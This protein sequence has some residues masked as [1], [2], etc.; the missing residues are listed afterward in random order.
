MR[1]RR[2]QGPPGWV[3]PAKAGAALAVALLAL[4]PCGVPAAQAAR[5]QARVTY[6][7]GGSVYV[8]AGRLEGL[9]EGDSLV[10]VRSGKPVAW[11]R[12]AFLSSHRASCDT[13][14][15]LAAIQVGD[16]VSFAT[17]VS[18]TGATVE[19]STA[20]A[21]GTSP[22]TGAPAPAA[23]VPV[24]VPAGPARAAAPPSRAAPRGGM[25]HGRVGAR[26]LTVQGENG[27][28]L[29]QPALD[30]RFDGMSLG[31]AP[32]D[33]AV[34]FR[35]RRITQS[36]AGLA[37]VNRDRGLFYRLAFATH[38]RAGRYRLTVGRQSSPALAPVSLFD[39]A[40]VERSGAR[41]SAGLF[42][43]TQPE[44]LRL[45]V[46]GAIAQGGGYAEWRQPSGS[47]RRW[48]IGGGAISSYDHGN[49][50][51]DFGFLQAYYLDRALS[52]TLAQEVDVNRGWKRD[53]GQPSLQA[54]G[55][56]LTANVRAGS[57]LSLRAGFDSR[58]NVWLYRDR[59]TPEN[60]FDDRNREGGW[61][62]ALLDVAHHVRLTG[63]ARTSSI[64]GTRR[65]DGWTGGVEGFRL[66][67]L[68][69]TLR[70]RYSRL[71]GS[72]LENS[73]LSFGAGL[74]PLDRAH[75]ELSGG[76]RTARESQAGVEE[77]TQWLGA[78]LDVTLPWRAY[79]SVSYEDDTGGLSRSQQAFLAL[80][81][82]F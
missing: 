24:P 62:G 18:A 2:V 74:D 47:A 51:R 38:D 13:L 16:V 20:A 32:L 9:G 56:F 37:T 35:G 67:P 6:L 57:A 17:G 63:D 52:A 68:N 80:S 1:A 71:A 27:R 41:W 75:V 42:G 66:T 8:D 61:G 36:G 23:S 59:T 4:L 39:G 3:R 65:Q 70:T 5:T 28:R 53:L 26:F 72:G 22:G 60:L 77:R 31:G 33:L 73:L 43:G 55:T 48:S 7:A 29:T 30:L 19:D 14:S 79:F 64:A 10:V 46:S 78:D 82:R 44:P 21:P 25:L 11:L 40:L 49:T 69:L 12:A 54:T 76:R 15:T 81:W 34:D 50:N 58:R 45:G